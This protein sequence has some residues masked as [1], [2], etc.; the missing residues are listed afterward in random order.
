MAGYSMPILD[1]DL[2]IAKAMYEVNV[3]GV[4]RTTQVFS[5]LV[6]A[7]EGTI[8]II[9]S[10]AGVMPYVFGGPLP[11]PFGPAASFT[12][13][14][15][16][17]TDP[18]VGAYNS[19]KAAIQSIADTLRIELYPFNVKVLN[20]STGGVKTNLSPNSITRWDLKLP[21]SSVYM[22]IEQHFKKRQGYSNANA[23][24]ASEYAKQV[25]NAVDGARR[26]GWIWKGYF[27][28]GAW[29][30]ST[31][32]WRTVF[33]IFMRRAFGLEELRSLVRA[34]KKRE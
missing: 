30:L 27:A 31:F 16:H 2:E 9:G 32:A 1:L 6:I 11:I 19:S 24:P 14:Q 22:P 5:S 3:W 7:A 18:F 26:S 8:V 29:A 23:I 10:I 34:R 17:D 12:P 21:P 15:I 20:I 28:F 4:I 13:F 33:D 25:V